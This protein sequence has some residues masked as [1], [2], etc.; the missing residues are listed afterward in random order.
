MCIGSVLRG[1]SGGPDSIHIGVL[2]GV[3][4]E[5]W[6]EVRA[7]PPCQP[8]RRS[9]LGLK[10]PHGSAERQRAVHSY[11]KELLAHHTSPQHTRVP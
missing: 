7:A 3:H 2:A 4:E 6:K 9:R 10:T 5:V 8:P 11:E 1:C